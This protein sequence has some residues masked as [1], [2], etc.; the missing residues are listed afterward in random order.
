MK[1]GRI[2]PRENPP[3]EKKKKGEEESERHGV[4]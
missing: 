2:S 3:P 1:R 4:H